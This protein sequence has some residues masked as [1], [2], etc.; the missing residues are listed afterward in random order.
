MNLYSFA[1]NVL[2]IVHLMWVVFMVVGIIA[3]VIGVFWRPVFR[4]RGWRWVHLIGLL[5]SAT[6]GIV[7]RPCPFTT[8]EYA[9]RRTSGAQISAEESFVIRLANRLIF[10][11]LEPVTLSVL[12]VLAAALVVGVF[13]LRPSWKL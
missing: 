4:I 6:L 2:V 13:I 7:G 3:T 8:W 12:T 1:A 10:P 9:L 11:E 5:F